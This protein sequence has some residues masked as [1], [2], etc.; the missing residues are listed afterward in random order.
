VAKKRQSRSKERETSPE[1]RPGERSREGQPGVSAQLQEVIAQ[2]MAASGTWKPWAS[3]RARSIPGFG[4][5]LLIYSGLISQMPLDHYRGDRRLEET[6][7]LFRPDPNH[8]RAWWVARMVEDYLEHGNAVH[9][10]MARD[11]EGRP[12]SVMWLPAHRV[13]LE[14]SDGDWAPP[15]YIL[16]GIPIPRQQD[17]VHIQRGADPS[18]P[19]RGIGV[20]EQHLQSLGRIYNQERFEANSLTTSGVPSVAII[21]PNPRIGDDEIKKARSQWD[22]LYGGVTRRPGIFPAGTLIKPLSWSPTDAQLS[23]ARQ[24]SLTD[25][26]NMFNLDG[27]WLGAPA[28]SHT[29]R[30]L[31]PAF[32]HLVRVSLE[33]VAEVLEQ[34]WG[35]RWL[36]R[37]QSLAFRRRVLEQGT[38]AEGVATVARG[39]TTI[40]SDGRPLMTTDEGRGEIGLPAQPPEAAAA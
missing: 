15:R 19:W 30:S 23:E 26:A 40:G 12:A 20:V 27:L 39:M 24:F 4:R 2:A 21:A 33:P 8:S 14:R 31:S 16:D 29:Y 13:S 3:S 17:V 10:V 7:L 34:E 32:T 37:G 1:T 6:R 36:P 9:L 5:A 28:S 18:F 38:L 11:A 25:M 22:E 35:Y